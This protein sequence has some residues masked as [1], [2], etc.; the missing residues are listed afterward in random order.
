VL[1]A[2]IARRPGPTA[3][4]VDNGYEF[5]SRAMDASAF[6][7]D[8][9]LELIRRGKPVENALIALQGPPARRVP[10][11]ARLASTAEIQCVLAWREDYNHLHPHSAYRIGRRR[12]GP[13]VGPTHVLPRESASIKKTSVRAARG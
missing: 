2:V 13:N 8:V 10:Q 4:T 11:R 12:N 1:K 6:A 7:H 3:I 5:V 9:R